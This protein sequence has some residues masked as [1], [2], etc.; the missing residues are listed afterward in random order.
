[1]AVAEDVRGERDGVARF[2]LKHKAAP[3]DLGADVFDNEIVF[4][5][6]NNSHSSHKLEKMPRIVGA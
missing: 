5:S 1:V 4:A 6:R 3:F 2:T